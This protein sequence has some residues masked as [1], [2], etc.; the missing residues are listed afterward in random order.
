MM[1]PP[2]PCRLVFIALVR[3]TTEGFVAVDAT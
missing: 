3:R 1:T 2:W